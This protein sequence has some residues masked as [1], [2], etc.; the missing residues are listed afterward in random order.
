MEIRSGKAT[1]GDI[2]LEYEDW[3]NINN[4]PMVLIMGLS[5]QM[6]LWPDGFC[7]QLV[8]EAVAADGACADWPAQRSALHAA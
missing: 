5:A 2:E 7:E 3:G 8:H 4:P 1:I 6:L